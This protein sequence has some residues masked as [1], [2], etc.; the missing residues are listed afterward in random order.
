MKDSWISV[1]TALP[2]FYTISEEWTATESVL[3]CSINEPNEYRVASYWLL[4]G[5]YKWVCAIEGKPIEVTHWQ[6][7]KGPTNGN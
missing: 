2:D 7:F 4:E 6:Y 5:K 3:V 1:K